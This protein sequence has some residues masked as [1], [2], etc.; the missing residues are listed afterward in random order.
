M[1]LSPH[2]SLRE[3]T[4][5]NTAIKNGIDNNPTEVHLSNMKAL[6]ENVLEPVRVHFGT[7]IRVGSGYRSEKLNKVI[8]GAKSSQHC[9]GEA[10]DIDGTKTTTNKM[11]FDFIR[12]NLEFDQMIWEFGDDDNPDWVHV[13]YTTHKKNRRQILRA[14]REGGKTVY[15]LYKSDDGSDGNP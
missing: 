15:T 14:S 6:C 1:K 12:K 2:F 7:P 10:A 11:V 13:S 9:R 3:F 4:R 5:S 8:G